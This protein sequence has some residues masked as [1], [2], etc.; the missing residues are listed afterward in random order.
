[1]YLYMQ[2]LNKKTSQIYTN[3][4]FKILQLVASAPTATKEREKRKKE[5][6]EQVENMTKYQQGMKS[7]KMHDNIEIMKTLTK[8]VGNNK[9]EG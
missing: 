3:R 7:T 1:M 6:K 5:R 8:R 4:Y 9:G 2:H